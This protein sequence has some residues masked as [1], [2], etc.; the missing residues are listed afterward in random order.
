MIKRL[1][2][3]ILIACAIFLVFLS[4][5]HTGEKYMP[6]VGAINGVGRI[7]PLEIYPQ[8]PGAIN[9]SITQANIGQNICNKNWST[10]SERPPSSYTSKLKIK[11]ISQ[12]GLTDTKPGDYEED[13]LISLELGGNPTDPNNLWPEPYAGYFATSTG[14]VYPG[15][16]IKDQVENYLH[17]QVCA[18]TIT[19]QTAQQE[20]ATDWYKVYVDNLQ[21]KYGSVEPVTDED[22]NG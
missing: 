15:A 8:V 4:W 20:I 10:S 21:G 19:L 2:I 5:T 3:F 11:Q 18:G 6:M 16:K 13:H 12:Y 17:A 22:D 1:G 9:A 7:G 14:I